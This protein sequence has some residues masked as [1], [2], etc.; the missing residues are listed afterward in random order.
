MSKPTTEDLAAWLV[1]DATR[2]A[3]HHDREVQPN[4][5]LVVAATRLRELEAENARLRA[6]RREFGERAL[7]RGVK[8]AESPPEEIVAIELD[9]I[10]REMEEEC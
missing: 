1:S 8:Y 2:A 5:L 3:K 4:D 6:S 7:H 10:E 9:A